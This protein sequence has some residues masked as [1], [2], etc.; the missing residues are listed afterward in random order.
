MAQRVRSSWRTLENV[1]VECTHCGVKM[2]MH[3]GGGGV[4]RYFRC[5]SCQR[6]VTSMYAEDALRADV[7]MRTR[8]LR[9]PQE[10][11]VLEAAK[12][13]LERFLGALEAQ[14]PFRTLGV[15]PSDSPERVRARYR[16]LALSAH[17]DRGGS[18]EQMRDLNLAYER[19]QAHA[20]RRAAAASVRPP[21]RRVALAAVST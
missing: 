20:E 4:V 2:V 19:V 9:A 8:P 10:G 21:V 16:E 14:D 12:A 3:A 15:S 1:E 5:T 11:L 7:K 13:K 6:H 18:A 17:P